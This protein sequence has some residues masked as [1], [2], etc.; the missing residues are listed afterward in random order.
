[1][2]RPDAASNLQANYYLALSQMKL[3][4]LNWHEA[5]EAAQKAKL[6]ASPTVKFFAINIPLN[7]GLA[8]TMAGQ[9]QQGVANCRLAVDDARALGDPALLAP[10]LLALAQAQVEAKDYAGAKANALE[11]QQLFAAAGRHDY[12]WLGWLIA[13]RASNATHESDQARDYGTRA[14]QVLAGLQ[15]QWGNDNYNSYLNR[16]DVQ[17]FRKQLEDLMAGRS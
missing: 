10:S 4:E 7:Q 11:A 2:L 9:S 15:S 8:L 3:S 17:L 6:V 14:Q 12:E 13:A 5:Q 16:P 1:V